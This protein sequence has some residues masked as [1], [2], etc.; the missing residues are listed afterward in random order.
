[1]SRCAQALGRLA[2]RLLVTIGND[3][4]CASLGKGFRCRQANATASTG[5]ECHFPIES[6]VYH[7]RYLT[8][9]RCNLYAAE[10]R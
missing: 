1:V 4:G 5:D 10:Y 3:H 7:D 8:C 2:D 6:W 9:R